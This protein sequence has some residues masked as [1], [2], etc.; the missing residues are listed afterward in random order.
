MNK[1]RILIAGLLLAMFSAAGTGLVAFTHQQ[2]KERIAANEREALLRSL[3]ALVPESTIDN[4]I[5]SDRTTVNSREL[6]GGEAVDV[7]LG[8]KSGEPVAAV[9]ASVVPD[10]Y[11]GPIKLLVAVRVDGTLG[12]VRVVSHKETPGL[13]DKVEERRSDWVYSFNDKSLDNPD[14]SRWKVK[15]DGGIFDQFA[16]ATITPRSIVNAVKNT[17]IYFREQGGPLFSAKAKPQEKKNG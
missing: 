3:T 9:F 7:Y 12:G 5:V 2:T 8:R 15:R 13:G 4:D 6:L 11:S 1:K 17:L 16:G 10:G 14:I